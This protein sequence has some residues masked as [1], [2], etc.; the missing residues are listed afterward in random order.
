MTTRFSEGHYQSTHGRA[1]R[2]RGMWAFE[3]TTPEGPQTRFYN[4][5]YTE[6]RNQAMR[7]ARANGWTAVT[8]MP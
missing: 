2:G 1:P 6:A 5:T 7:E 8:V 4:G 3:M